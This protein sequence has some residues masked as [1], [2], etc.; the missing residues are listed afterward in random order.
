M[1]HKLEYTSYRPDPGSRFEVILNASINALLIW[2]YVGIDVDL[3]VDIYIV[4]R[5]FLTG[6]N[7]KIGYLFCFLTLMFCIFNIRGRFWKDRY[8]ISAVKYYSAIILLS[9]PG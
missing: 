8:H 1:N 9:K 5:V 4:A 7:E 2:Y 6:S 3:S